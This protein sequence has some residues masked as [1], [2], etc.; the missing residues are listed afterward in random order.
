M[1]K[2]AFVRALVSDAEV[3]PIDEATSNLDQ[4]SKEK[5]F[6][7]LPLKNKITIIN[8]THIPESFN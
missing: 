8:S 2:I 7:R 3:L 4:I 6:K 5:V 1:Q